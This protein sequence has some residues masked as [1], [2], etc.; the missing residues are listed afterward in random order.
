[1]CVREYCTRRIRRLRTGKGL[2]LTQGRGKKFEKKDVV[3]EKV[4]DIRFVV[5]V[6]AAGSA[7]AAAVH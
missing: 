7:A 3:A 1:V 5:D 4:T 2:K 6:V